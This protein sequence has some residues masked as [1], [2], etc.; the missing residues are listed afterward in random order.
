MPKKGG[1][2]RSFICPG[3]NFMT[4]SWEQMCNTH[5]NVQRGA[6]CR[7][8]FNACVGCDFVSESATGL[9][10]HYNSPHKRLCREKKESF[11]N[12][13]VIHPPAP[14]DIEDSFTFDDN[15]SSN[16]IDFFAEYLD[17][18]IDDSK[19][20]LFSRP[21]ESTKSVTTLSIVEDGNAISRQ[22]ISSISPAGDCSSFIAQ[23]RSAANDG[24]SNFSK[25]QYSILN[26]LP[27]TGHIPPSDTRKERIARIRDQ[28]HR[29]KERQD[30]FNDNESMSGVSNS[31]DSSCDGNTPS[32]EDATSEN[33]DD[34]NNEDH[35]EENVNNNV[36]DR[37]ASQSLSTLSAIDDINKTQSLLNQLHFGPEDHTTMDLHLTLKKSGVPLIL[38][39]RIVDWVTVHREQLQHGISKRNVSSKLL[40]KKLYSNDVTLMPRLDEIKLSSNRTTSITTFSLKAAIVELVTNKTHFNAKN[41]LFN[42]SNPW[43]RQE[44]DCDLSEPN[45]GEW[46]R[47]ALKMCRDLGPRVLLFNI[48]AFID[49]LNIDKFGKIGVECIIIQWLFMTKSFRNTEDC[50]FPL[51]F[52]EDQKHFKD[53]NGYV[54]EEKMQDYHDM[55]SHIF[56]E[57][58]EIQEAGGILM[59]LDFGDGNVH[60]DVIVYP[61]IQYIMCDCKGADVLCG[62]KGTHSLNTPWLCRDC[63]VPSRRGHDTEFVCQWTKM[64][65]IK[66][67]TKEE[68][69]AMSHFKL[70]SNAFHKITMGLC[71]RNIHGNSCPEHLHHIQ[72]GVCHDIGRSLNFTD[73]G[74]KVFTDTFCKIYPYASCQSDRQMPSL[75]P[76]RRGIGS[77]KC[78]KAKERFARVFALYLCLMNSHCIKNLTEVKLKGEDIDYSKNTVATLTGYLH[79]IEE[80]LA[81]HEW[82]KQGTIKREQLYPERRSPAEIR[83]K[84][85]LKTF[86]DNILLD[87]N[88]YDKPKPHQL[89]HLCDIIRRHG[90]PC[91]IDGSRGEFMGK[92]LVKDNA[93][94]TNKNRLSLSYD[95]ALRYAE[96]RCI[97]RLDQVRTEQKSPSTLKFLKPPVV[98]IDNHLPTKSTTNKT[99]EITTYETDA[100]EEIETRMPE[101]VNV[102]RIE[103]KWIG[104]VPPTRSY[105]ASLLDSVCQRLFYHNARIGGR[106][107]QTES[108]RGMTEYRPP[109]NPT[110]IYRASP[111]FRKKGEWYDWA[112]FDWDMHGEPVPARILMFLDLRTS[113]ILDE[114]P[115]NDIVEN[116]APIRWLTNEIWCVVLAAKGEEVLRGSDNSPLTPYHLDSILCRRIELE[117]QFRIVP[118]SAI[119]GTAYVIDNI[120]IRDEDIADNT[121]IVIKDITEWPAAFMEG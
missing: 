99:F 37:A 103:I 20:L 44:V 86:Q 87:G 68:L 55:V 85:F 39:D 24:A 100:E 14:M 65:D 16:E 40:M 71:V 82:L 114:E 66:G 49:E 92:V 52:I 118:A 107:S 76:F 72:M 8:Y 27:G 25:N 74:N 62:R 19:Q 51:G 29:A 46:M 64:R 83:I 34:T 47:G 95:I 38:F 22:S 67:K 3:C 6:S 97:N 109:D 81:L 31:S 1:R 121:A 7:E 89:L 73:S 59:D 111:Y 60:K 104:C 43:E 101:T 26:S 53:S 113:T 84:K 63:N 61:D 88:K 45:T 28:I 70:K 79:A 108:L 11:A 12:I 30:Y 91:N 90:A 5:L 69:A 21:S 110:Q 54:R 41:V 23:Q 32:S 119:S 33:E 48:G 56:K 96:G 112:Y 18:D 2:K 117:D 35:N 4:H 115:R 120:P 75:S 50:W 57:L 93:K 80:T 105:P 17:D 10:C 9:N 42:T 102:R 98:N 106:L 15:F 77:V 78:L 94:L 116:G 36:D 13:D 58:R